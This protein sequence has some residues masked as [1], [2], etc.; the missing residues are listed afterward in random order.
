MAK[1][2]MQL[3]KAAVC[4]KYRLLMFYALYYVKESNPVS[5]DIWLQEYFFLDG[6][7]SMGGKCMDNWSKVMKKIGFSTQKS[8]AL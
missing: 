8:F 5:L 6:K 4:R 7:A 2:E 3:Q 1:S